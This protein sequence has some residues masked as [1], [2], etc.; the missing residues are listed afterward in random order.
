MILLIRLVAVF[1]LLLPSE[2][3]SESES[4]Q[5]MSIIIDDKH[6]IVVTI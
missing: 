3:E 2:S 4:T 1:F 5:C 6:S